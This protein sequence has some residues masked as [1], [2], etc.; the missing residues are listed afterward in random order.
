[1]ILFFFPPTGFLCVALA[2]LSTHS[3]DQ[4][5]LESQICLPLPPEWTEGTQS[6]HDF[7]TS[8]YF[9]LSLF[10]CGCPFRLEE[11][12]DPLGDEVTGDWELSYLGKH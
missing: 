7:K 4:G 1:M 2:V 12:V 6:L 11:G 5:A 10:A 9:E 3:V 8:F